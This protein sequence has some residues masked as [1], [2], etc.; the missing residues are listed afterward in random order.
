[1]KISVTKFGKILKQ[2]E[3]VIAW[4][5][6][7]WRFYID[8]ICPSIVDMFLIIPFPHFA[9]N[10]RPKLAHWLS[11]E[12]DYGNNILHEMQ[13]IICINLKR[14]PLSLLLGLSS[15]NLT[16]VANRR[17]FN[18]LTLAARKNL[19]L[20]W[21]I[22][23]PPSVKGW[24]KKCWFELIPLEYPACLIHSKTDFF[25]KHGSPFFS[26]DCTDEHFVFPWYGL[27]WCNGRLYRLSGFY[28]IY[29]LYFCMYIL[30]RYSEF[31]FLSSV[32]F[33]GKK[34]N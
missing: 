19:L 15:D 31:M 24:Q 3:S 8:Y 26:L 11:V 7:S 17:L 34:G 29:L 2:Y 18:I 5:Q 23:K 10:A 27:I 33:W 14:D 22:D 30:L 9:L 12:Q 28:F 1:M 25:I 20:H 6:F 21:I 16:S 32:L 4:K 13:K